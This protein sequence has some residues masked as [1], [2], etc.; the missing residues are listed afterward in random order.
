MDETCQRA[1]DQIN[2]GG[3]DVLFANTCRLFHVPSIA[4]HVQIPKVLYLQEPYRSLYE[5]SPRLPWAALPPPKGRLDRLSYG[6]RLA[7]DLLR[8]Q[9]LRVQV[10]EEQANAQAFDTILVNSFFSRESILRSYGFE[11]AVCYLGMDT[12]K[13]V[14]RAKPRENFVVGVGSFLPQKNIHLVIEAVARVRPPR[15]RLIWVGNHRSEPYVEELRRLA[16][17]LGV[18]FEERFLI[19]DEELI[20]ILNRA[21]LMVY[22]PRLEP[23]GYAPL[24]AGACELPVVGVSEG[25]LRESIVDGVNG[26][27][28]EPV[29]DAL[30]GAIERIQC[31]E[32]YARRL[33]RSGRQLV[34]DRWSLNAG[35][36]RVEAR[37]AATVHSHGCGVAAASGEGDRVPDGC[38]ALP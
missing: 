14:S 6:K 32:S 8:V 20:D 17:S 26:L 16:S 12:D 27:L 25:G 23:F 30:A 10:R 3:F 15:P 31:D 38:A 13:F 35:I 2:A 9:A 24:E 36:D 37:L 21:S 28:V 7:G 22:A 19:D 33:G 1:A 18:V 5:A 34:L 11:A 29:P 4:Q